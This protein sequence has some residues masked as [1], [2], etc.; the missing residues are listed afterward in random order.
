MRRVEGE[1][2]KGIHTHVRHM[3]RAGKNEKGDWRLKRDEERRGTGGSRGEMKMRVK[4]KV[5][6]LFLSCRLQCTMSRGECR[7]T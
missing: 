4:G 5:C 7:A 6:P 3:A 1:E 2:G